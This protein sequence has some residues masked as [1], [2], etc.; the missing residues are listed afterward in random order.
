MY[1][2]KI[3]ST[4]AAMAVLSTGLMAFDSDELGNIQVGSKAK[5]GYAGGVQAQSDLN[6][7][8]D[9]KGDALI[10][11][12]WR[13][14]N[15]WA[16]E[17]VVR[18]TTPK[19]TVAKVVLYAKRDSEE[20]IDFNVYLSP[21]DAVRFT[22][23]D[24]F[25]TSSDGSIVLPDNAVNPKHGVTHDNDSTEHLFEHDVKTFKVNPKAIE[26]AN[27]KGKSVGYA[28]VY[29]MTQYNDGDT[30]VNTGDDN[31]RLNYHGGES[32]A[33][34]MHRELFL[35]YRRVLDD[36]RPGWRNAYK[37]NLNSKPSFVHGMMTD[38]IKGG[39]VPAPDTNIGCAGASASVV[40]G[41]DLSN[42]GDVAKNTLIGTVRVFKAEDEQSRD[43]LLRA[44]ALNNFTD[45]NM[46]LWS[47]G[48]YA[49]IQD[50]RIAEGKYQEDGIRADA[51]TFVVKS[52]YYT[53]AKD[54]KENK[55]II[56]QPMKRILGQLG[57]DDEYWSNFSSENPYGGF[58]ITNALFDE[59]E[60]I[61]GELLN[62]T[63]GTFTSPFNTG[64]TTDSTYNDELHELRDLEKEQGTSDDEGIP[65]DG[66][67]NS[68]Y[69]G[70]TNGFIYLTFQGNEDG[71]PAIITQMTGSKV[72][73]IAQTNWIY[74]PT[75]KSSDLK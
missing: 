33:D 27:Y 40:D 5:A 48:E 49:A 56:T 53:Y 64:T 47:E 26:H 72:G 29:G 73:H 75:I 42:F 22:I 67:A 6:L 44:T 15:G 61:D 28:I 59:N 55:L 52:A 50:R 17:I 51:K 35:D 18:N 66:V 7:S 13:M 31:D 2:K 65:Y 19:A 38:A 8:R 16:T 4:V 11:P 58:K 57:N 23:K 20:L 21:F 12:F 71:I 24:G 43:L 62:I 54:S 25:I 39:S 41:Y 70:S 60:R 9:Q 36:C 37:T 63:T 1:S 14:D 74:A 68:D 34:S 69:F 45:G 3:L 10:F 46:L 32:D 30:I